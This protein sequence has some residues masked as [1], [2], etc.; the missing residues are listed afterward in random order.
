MRPYVEF[1]RRG[2]GDFTS[3]RAVKPVRAAR[4]RYVAS[5]KHSKG[6]QETVKS[7]PRSVRAHKI[8]LRRALRFEPSEG[9]NRSGHKSVCSS[10][11]PVGV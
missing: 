8:E 4:R 6:A 11:L 7:V 2:V 1:I 5:R 9:R 3:L 10:D